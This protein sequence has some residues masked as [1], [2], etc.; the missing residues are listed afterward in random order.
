VLI[1]TGHVVSAYVAGTLVFFPA[2]NEESSLPG[3]V[4]EARESLPWVDLLVVDDGSSD[5]TAAAA[6]GTGGD[7]ACSLV[8]AT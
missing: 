7:R 8:H 3:V 6:A 2:W 5:G 1:L 4:A